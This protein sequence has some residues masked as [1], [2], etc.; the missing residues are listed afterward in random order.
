MLSCIKSSLWC[1]SLSF[2]LRDIFNWVLKKI[3]VSYVNRSHSP[4]TNQ[5][6]DPWWHLGN[7]IL[8][9]STFRKIILFFHQLLW[10]FS[11]ERL[12]SC[13]A[14]TFNVH[15]RCCAVGKLCRSVCWTVGS[16][17]NPKTD[18]D[19]NKKIAAVFHSFYKQSGERLASN[20]VKKKKIK[21]TEI[22]KQNLFHL[23]LFCA[24]MQKR[25]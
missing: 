4:Q 20:L 11:E 8:L 3:I 7:S 17:K 13:C 15:V 10:L 14:A 19:T 16:T 18:V 5:R 9:V 23:N 6:T 24:C 22:G 2:F 12:L 25:L 1:Q 21:K